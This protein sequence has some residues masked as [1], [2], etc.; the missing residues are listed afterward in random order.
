[1]EVLLGNYYSTQGI[2]TA[3]NIYNFPED[4]K[5]NQKFLTRGL[6][7][8]LRYHNKIGYEN[9][10][11]KVD[12]ERKANQLFNRFISEN[13]QEGV[14]EIADIISE[15]YPEQRDEILRRL[16]DYDEFITHNTTRIEQKE[17][18]DYRRIQD[19]AQTRSRNVITKL[20]TVYSDSQNVH[21]TKI[22]NSVNK[23]I[24]TLFDMFKV[25]II[26]ETDKEEDKHFNKLNMTRE[27]QNYL[28]QKYPQQS[29]LI[30]ESIEYINGS[31]ATFTS[32]FIGMIDCF[33][34]IWIWIVN[35]EHKP[36]LEKRLLEEFSEMKDQCATGH[37]SRLINTLQGFTDN[38]DLIVQISETEQYTSVIKTFLSKCLSDCKDEKIHEEMLTGGER[39]V[40][41]IKK[42]IQ[43]QE[44]IWIKEY[45][46]EIKSYIPL[47]VNSYTNTKIFKI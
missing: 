27:I 35:H 1:M 23:A 40:S 42:Q 3:L 45:S 19:R 31:S 38:P 47:I 15:F 26:T 32:D 41:F 9:R 25:Q 8:L 16:R 44:P 33:L 13:Y 22:N 17:R 36:E 28:I 43:N 30:K 12:L 5:Y 7:Y 20:N 6:R 46:D 18:R 4:Y 39:F 29:E 11:S 34:C 24:K 2:A 37:V 21:S 10:I 14:R